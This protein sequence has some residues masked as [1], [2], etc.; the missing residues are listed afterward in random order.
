M[1]QHLSLCQV[2]LICLN[3]IILI[4]HAISSNDFPVLRFKRYS[5]SPTEFPRAAAV[6]SQCQVQEFLTLARQKS[7]CSFGLSL[8]K[9]RNPSKLDKG[10]PREHPGK[11][12]ASSPFQPTKQQSYT[13]ITTAAT[14]TTT[15]STATA[16]DRAGWH[17]GHSR[18]QEK[19]LRWEIMP[20]LNYVVSWY[21]H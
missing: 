11:Q 1:L 19:Y 18:T 4:D 8:Y 6:C 20:V 3:S 7:N 12:G 14:S 10:G 5:D 9:S 21:P 2:N 13:E 15:R 17:Q 16:N